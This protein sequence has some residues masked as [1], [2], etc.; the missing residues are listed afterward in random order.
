MSGVFSRFYGLAPFFTDVSAFA[1][2]ICLILKFEDVH[3]PKI[4]YAAIIVVVEC[5]KQCRVTVQSNGNTELIESSHIARMK[6][7]ILCKGSISVSSNI[8]SGQVIAHL[9]RKS[10]AIVFMTEPELAVVIVS[11]TLHRCVV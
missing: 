9:R 10:T 11:P 3:G 2:K 5:P 6:F 8:Y 7:T 4:L 1:R